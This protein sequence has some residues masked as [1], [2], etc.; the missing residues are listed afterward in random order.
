MLL[1]RSRFQ[2][3]ERVPTLYD[4]DAD[5]FGKMLTTNRS[6]STLA[7]FRLFGNRNLAFSSENFI[8]GFQ[9]SVLFN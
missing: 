5:P 2:A 3:S 8:F 6:L 9:R 4:N 7:L 1:K